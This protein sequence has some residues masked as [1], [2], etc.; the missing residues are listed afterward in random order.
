MSIPI[1]IKRGQGAPTS[2]LRG[3][4]AYDEVNRSLFV[5]EGTSG[6]DAEGRPIAATI[7]ELTT[8]ASFLSGLEDVFVADASNND[9]LVYNQ[10]TQSWIA[11]AVAASSV[12]WADV[13]GKPT[14]FTPD[15]HTHAWGDITSGVPSSFTPSAHASSHATG[16]TDALA[17]ADIGAA[18]A[19]HT[20]GSVTN[21]GKV[22]STSGLVL[23]TGAAGV[24]E[25]L[26]LGAAGQVLKVNDGAT[27]IEWG[28]ATGI[29]SGSIA[30]DTIWSAK[31]EIVA[32]TGNDAA[33]AVTVGTN[34]QSLVADSTA[35]AGLA[36]KTL[37]ASD[38]GAAATSHTHALAD[39]QQGGATENQVVTW[40]G[41]A[42]APAT[43]SGGSGGAPAQ[44]Q[45]YVNLE[46]FEYALT[47]REMVL[48][49]ASGGS[50]G[51]A[52]VTGT[53]GVVNITTGTT[54]TANAHATWRLTNSSS[55]NDLS[56][57][58]AATYSTLVRGLN[59]G[60]GTTTGF[61]FCGIARLSATPGSDPTNGVYFRA[62]DGGNWY[63]VT[64]ASNTETATD[65]G[66]SQS[67]SLW[68][69]LTAKYTASSCTFF[70]DGSLVAT[71]TTNIP[72]D[73]FNYGMS[74]VKTAA[75]TSQIRYQV[76]YLYI[77][78]TY[79]NAV[80]VD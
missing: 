43:P 59:L 55:A 24:I 48:A 54:A 34:G 75:V 78:H 3:E 47:P 39:I 49:T 61:V 12:A 22:G 77:E 53:V 10:A 8:P 40:N 11:Q 13:T 44:T 46:H 58:S 64:R 51:G 9:V 67:T 35:S 36:W 63:A 41:T 16:G 65:T 14:G 33:V 73:D 25:T 56:A 18:A 50:V 1:R 20:H 31:G 37:A 27:N 4:L 74:V 15:T 29:G 42:W 57:V 28:S 70:I 30:T 68:R 72:T 52:S 71:H 38:V 17:P 60:D 5:G 76:D 79:A 80:V 23:K 45:K 6:N 19:S 2:L 62:T 66:V 21:D 69:R 7:R 32:A 26:A